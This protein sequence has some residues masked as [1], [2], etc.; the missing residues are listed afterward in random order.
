MYLPT[1]RKNDIFI[2]AIA[3]IIIV[4]NYSGSNSKFNI[5]FN[6]PRFL[7]TN[8]PCTEMHSNNVII[9]SIR[10]QSA[11]EEISYWDRIYFEFKIFKYNRHQNPCDISDMKIRQMTSKLKRKFRPRT[12]RT[13]LDA[14]VR[15]WGQIITWNLRG[16]TEKYAGVGGSTQV[17]FYK[18]YNF[19]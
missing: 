8:P 1:A 2:S 10:L 11:L 19:F 14:C 6:W 16:E 15:Q 13:V 12:Y 3:L 4:D 9:S 17:D 7:N 18:H 5:L